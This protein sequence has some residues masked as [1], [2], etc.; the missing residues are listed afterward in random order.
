MVPLTLPDAPLSRLARATARASL[1]S[2]IS[3]LERRAM[4]ALRSG[5]LL[6]EAELGER[7]DAIVE[8]NLLEDLAVLEA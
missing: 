7:R 8:T 3:H 1:A 4:A 6:E 5:G 2:R